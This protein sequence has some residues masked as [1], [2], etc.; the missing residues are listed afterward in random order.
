MK[1]KISISIKN[2]A[3]L[4]VDGKTYNGLTLSNGVKVKSGPSCTDPTINVMYFEAEQDLEVSPDEGEF[5][6]TEFVV[7]PTELVG[8]IGATDRN[9]E[10]FL[11]IDRVWVAKET[12][13]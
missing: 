1:D 12:A 6:L 10:H 11:T 7:V 9:V 2:S 8:P 5:V 13:I 4:V 3:Q